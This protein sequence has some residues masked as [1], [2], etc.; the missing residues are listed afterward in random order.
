MQTTSARPYLLIFAVVALAVAGF[1]LK[2]ELST[3]D[4]P[5]G[6]DLTTPQRLL[7]EEKGGRVPEKF[8]D[9]FKRVGYEK[10][11][12]ASASDMDV[13]KA[14][15]TGGRGAE[16]TP[17]QL[18]VLHKD[19]ASEGIPKSLGISL[20]PGLHTPELH[21]EF[22]PE[23]KGL[24]AKGSPNQNFRTI[25]SSWYQSDPELVKSLQKDPDKDLAAFVKDIITGIEFPGKDA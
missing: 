19:L 1:I 2:Q 21:K 7:V 23:V 12:F 17:D 9:W 6:D 10:L 20:L 5:A 25:L 4:K 13:T 22:L 18:K 24:F 15:L 14:M 3:V 11:G 16:P 8:D